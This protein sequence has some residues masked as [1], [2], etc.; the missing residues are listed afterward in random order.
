MEEAAKKDPEGAAGQTFSHKG[1]WRGRKLWILLCAASL[2]A[3]VILLMVWALPSSQT[4]EEGEV[5]ADGIEE[6]V[7]EEE[8]PSGGEETP[9]Q[10]A[11]PGAQGGD[12]GVTMG[13][14][15]GGSEPDMVIN[16]PDPADG[17]GE[18]PPPGGYTDA[19][20]HWVLDMSGSE[21]GFS[22][23]HIVLE[24]NG[25]ISSPPEYDPVFEIAASTYEWES[26]NPAFTASLQVMLK[27]GAGQALVPVTIELSGTVSS[28]FAEI[29][30]DFIAT[31]QGEIYAPYSQR[32][33]FVMQR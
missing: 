3:L 32:G 22:N 18:E 15:G 31:P 20:G 5:R 19:Y 26:G 9:G 17:A 21:Y 28:S 33:T 10:P 29:S 12:E 30:G 8:T 27:L 4:S 16:F 7:E 6:A 25:A 14:G 24:E 1:R 13:P 23:C 11:E 2:A